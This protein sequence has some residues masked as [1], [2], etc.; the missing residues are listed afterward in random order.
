MFK[1][2]YQ[3]GLAFEILSCQGQGSLLNWRINNKALV[4]KVYERDIK[5]PHL[6]RDFAMHATKMAK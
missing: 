1:H 2:Q 3:G 6:S 5:V 4:K